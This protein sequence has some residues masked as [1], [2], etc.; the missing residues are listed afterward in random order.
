GGDVGELLPVE[1]SR[2]GRPGLGANAVGGGDRAVAGVLVEVDEDP[3]AALLLP[4]A[5]RHLVGQ[6]ALELARE[7][8]RSVADV[9]EAPERLDPYVDVY[10]A[11]PGRLR[12]AD[13]TQLLE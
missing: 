12:K 13:Q 4:P 2:H 1:R 7:R 5:G 9:R 8:D 11:A 10:P 3:L 6:P